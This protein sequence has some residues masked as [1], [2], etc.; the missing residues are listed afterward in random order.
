MRW[1]WEDKGREMM[2]RGVPAM[3]WLCGPP[4]RPGNTVW[5]IKD[6]KLYRVSFPLASTLRTPGENR[7]KKYQYRG[8]KKTNNKNKKQYW[9]QNRKRQVVC[10]GRSI[11]FHF[12]LSCR[13]WVQSG[14]HAASCVLS[15]KQYHS[16]Q[17]AKAPLQQPPI[18]WCEPCLPSDR[19]HSH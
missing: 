1:T 15:W 8:G 17:R 18:H 9:W 4:C 3:A 5:L 10:F 19:H 16:S 7:K 2:M 12:Y 14:S 6:S 11:I 13:R